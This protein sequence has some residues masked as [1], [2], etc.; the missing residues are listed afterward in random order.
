[1]PVT[2]R[3]QRRHLR[4]DGA[5]GAAEAVRALVDGHLEWVAAYPDGARFMYQAI[6]VELRAA[7]VAAKEELKRPLFDRLA[8]FDLPAW[9]PRTI[10]FVLLGPAHAACRRH[11]A[12]KDVA[13]G[14]LRTNR[15]ELATRMLF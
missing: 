13:L 8:R 3:C 7:V 10:E 5:G 9:P 12:G 6:A 15:P 1:L 4:L 14:W 2:A 11:F